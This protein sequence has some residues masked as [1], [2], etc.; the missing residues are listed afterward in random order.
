MKLRNLSVW[1]II[2]LLLVPLTLAACQSPQQEPVDFDEMPLDRLIGTIKSL[3]GATA[4]QGTHL[5]QLDDGDTILLRSVA[6][7]L[8]KEDYKSAVVEVRG[9]ITI[10]NDSRQL[11][12]VMNIDILDIKIEEDE[13]EV[14]WLE[15]ADKA[16]GFTIKYRSD[17]AVTDADSGAKFER[18]VKIEED[19]AA[20]EGEIA[21][22][23]GAFEITP[24]DVIEIIVSPKGEDGS[25]QDYLGLADMESSTL[26]AENMT[27]S[28]VGTDNLDAIKQVGGLDVD[29]TFYVES[30]DNIYTLTLS[31]GD[32]VDSLEVENI[33]FDMLNSFAVLAADDGEEDND[34]DEE[35]VEPE[36]T[37]ED[38]TEEVAEEDDDL[39][40]VEIPSVKGYANFEHDTLGFSIKYPSNW[41]FEG[42]V[43]GEAGVIRHYDFGIRAEDESE[44]TE[45]DDEEEESFEVQGIIGFDVLSGSIPEG[46]SVE[47][48]GKSVTKSTSGGSL[49]YYYEGSDGYIY[50]VTG[51]SEVQSTLE[52]MISSVNV[53]SE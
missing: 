46:N 47:L 31:S 38:D 39:A 22:E 17:F 40:D 15:F 24:M 14:E 12:D 35:E 4:G 42:T 53:T 51:P 18:A 16:D 19:E 6:I 25:L 44:D 41:Y 10:T 26:L 5:L 36:E 20:G 49:H 52:T 37:D 2:G 23:D 30:M 1:L 48:D 11:M 9:V 29:L 27:K 8:D 33:F 3:G 28:K 45:E 32:K 50:H 13:A 43:S 34:E 7:N 21:D